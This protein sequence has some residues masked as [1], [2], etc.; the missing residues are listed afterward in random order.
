MEIP[1]ESSDKV[2]GILD[3]KD[4][5]NKEK[6]QKIHNFDYD[7]TELQTGKTPTMLATTEEIKEELDKRDNVII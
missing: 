3:R 1:R 6:A 7:I 2:K 5:T 4:L